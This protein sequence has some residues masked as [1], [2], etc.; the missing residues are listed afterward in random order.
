M[1][2]LDKLTHRFETQRD[3]A[4]TYSPLYTAVWAALAAWC[5][6]QDDP[7]VRFL[8]EAGAERSAFDV[9]LLLVAGLHRDVLLGETAVADL[10]RFY[11]TAGGRFDPHRDAAALGEALYAAVMARRDALA[12]FIGSR[13]VQ[14]NETGRGIAWL[15]P[16][17]R[18]GWP[19]VHLVDLGASAGLNLVAERRAFRLKDGVQRVDLGSGRPVQFES[20]VDGLAHLW[21]AGTQ[22]ALPQI[23]SRTGCDLHPFRLATAEDEAT[24]ASY[25]WPDQVARLE[26]LREGI[27]AYRAA[28]Q[29]GAPVVLHA[30]RLPDDLPAFLRDHVPQDER[31]VLVYSTYVTMYLPQRGRRLRAHM[32]A[33]AASQPRPVWWVQWE[34][35]ENLELA[36]ATEP[37][38]GWLAW[39]LDRWEEGGHVRELLGWTHP[40]GQTMTL[41]PGNFAPRLPNG[42]THP[43]HPFEEKE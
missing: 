26:R 8:L 17:L 32:A 39:T 43:P 20:A 31:P 21:P 3:F 41:L 16:L 18:S 10:A 25:I 29:A 12:A 23:V 40:H 6:R 35:V 28:A 19:A 37:V 9:P 38:F 15:L 30:V 33:W 14:T 13:T 11:P 34:P 36:G 2:S 27:V 1:L 5:K 24:L 22:A 42:Q 7:L 4:A